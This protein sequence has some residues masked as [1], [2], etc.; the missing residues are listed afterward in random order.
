[1]N[2]RSV[3]SVLTLRQAQDGAGRTDWKDVLRQSSFSKLK[4]EQHERIE[5]RASDSLSSLG[6]LRQAQEGAGRDRVSG[7][8]R[9]SPDK[10]FLDLKV[11]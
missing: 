3:F 8:E 11:A 7:L 6:F 10:R 4:T 9:H 1:M 5:K 2:G